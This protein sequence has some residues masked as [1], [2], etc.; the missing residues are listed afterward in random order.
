MKQKEQC[1][2]LK[3]K[4]QDNKIKIIKNLCHKFDS[5][6]FLIPA[7]FL[8]VFGIMWIALDVSCICLPLQEYKGVIRHMLT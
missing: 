3:N 7:L 8:V 6:R 5:V 1:F 2:K 4:I